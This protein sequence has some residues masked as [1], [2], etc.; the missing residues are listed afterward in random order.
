MVPATSGRS[1]FVTPEG[2]MGLAPRY[3]EKGDL[4]RFVRLL[5]TDHHSK[6]K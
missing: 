3:A 5:S 6:V 4:I 2:Y 1:F